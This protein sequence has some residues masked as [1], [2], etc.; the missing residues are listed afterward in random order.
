MTINY[1]RKPHRLIRDKR[2][3]LSH[4]HSHSIRSQFKRHSVALISLVVAVVSLGYNT[5][6]N[7]TSELHRNWR[8]ASFEITMEVNELQQI[9]LYRRYFHGRDD[10]P[11]VPL[12]DAET[13]IGGWG[14]ATS[15]RDLTSLLP[16]PLPQRG[17]ALFETWQK[18]A[19][20]LEAGGREAADAEQALLDA[21]DDTR[22][23]VLDL[24][25]QL[26]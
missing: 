25:E 22:Q 10:H 3:Q 6:R 15:I 17:R 11:F 24:I 12:R 20:G 13:W 14:K 5:W 26:R 7:E 19:G 21:L 9:V 8:Q 16:D 18:N 23:S 4:L 1:S 2:K